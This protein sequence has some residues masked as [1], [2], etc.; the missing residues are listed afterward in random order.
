MATK[1]VK[2]QKNKLIFIKT[3]FT[4]QTNKQA[5]RQATHTENNL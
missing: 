1:W 5:N 2:Q 4:I 3:Q